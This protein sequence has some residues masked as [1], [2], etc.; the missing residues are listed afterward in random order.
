[1]ITGFV[2]VALA[3]AS[4]LL[5]P[6]YHTWNFVPIGAIALYAGSRLPRKWAWTVPVVA[7]IVGH[8][9]LGFRDPNGIRPL[10][11]GR[12]DTPRG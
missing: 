12:R 8:G 1:M 6:I 11:L 5:V 10:V 9:I 4:R 7:M 2:L 3:V